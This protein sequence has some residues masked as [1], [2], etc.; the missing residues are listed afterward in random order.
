MTRYGIGRVD[1]IHYNTLQSESLHTMPAQ[2][3][4]LHSFIQTIQSDLEKINFTELSEIFK[5]K[6]QGIDDS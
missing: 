3:T 2:N 4:H 6:I 1:A 5:N